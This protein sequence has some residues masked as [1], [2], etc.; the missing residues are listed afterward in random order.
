MRFLDAGS[1]PLEFMLDQ[2]TG[3]ATLDDPMQ[4]AMQGELLNE[5]FTLKLKASSLAGFLAMTHAE[6]G[7]DIDIAVTE[8]KFA[9]Q[10]EA[11]RGNRST[12]LKLVSKGADLSSLNE[13]LEL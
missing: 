3:S 12:L 1:E 2:A 8:Q 13:L 9:G 4:L 5:A 7:L 6:L 10:S 11:L